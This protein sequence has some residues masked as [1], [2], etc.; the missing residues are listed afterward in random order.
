[1]P[2]EVFPSENVVPSLICFGKHSM[3]ELQLRR[4]K[5]AVCVVAL[6]HDVFGEENGEKFHD[7]TIGLPRTFFFF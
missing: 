5:Y 1:M 4:R 2:T 3:G 6:V 7:V